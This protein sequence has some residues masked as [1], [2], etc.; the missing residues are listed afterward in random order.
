[1]IER[2]EQS[3]LEES[4]YTIEIYQYDQPFK[5]TKIKLYKESI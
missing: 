2:Q 3:K 4:L 5:S 1:M